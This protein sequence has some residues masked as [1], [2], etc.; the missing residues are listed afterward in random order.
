MTIIDTDTATYCVLPQRHINIELPQENIPWNVDETPSQCCVLMSENSAPFVMI[1]P[2]PRTPE[3]WWE[4]KHAAQEYWDR[5]DLRDTLE[6]GSENFTDEEHR[7]YAY[8]IPV[9]VS[10]LDSAVQVVFSQWERL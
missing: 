4:L 10:F 2:E 6:G 5:L 7:L 8:G 1:A 9:I 3:Q